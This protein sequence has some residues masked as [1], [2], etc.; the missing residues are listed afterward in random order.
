MEGVREKG[1]VKNEILLISR[2][3]TARKW[4]VLE[5]DA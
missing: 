5:T 3:K 4:A 1:G 2:G